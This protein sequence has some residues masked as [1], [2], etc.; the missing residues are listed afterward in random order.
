MLR[1]QNNA[2]VAKQCCGEGT[3]KVGRV[4]VVAVQLPFVRLNGLAVD[5]DLLSKQS[6]VLSQIF[7]RSLDAPVIL[8]T[9]IFPL[10]VFWA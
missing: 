10:L 3:D 9:S 8:V 2:A 7:R 1:R 5:D 4:V 6:S